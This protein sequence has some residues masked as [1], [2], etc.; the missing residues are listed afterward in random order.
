MSRLQ[1][2]TQVTQ[3]QKQTISGWSV[4]TK[5]MSKALKAQLEK[6][7]KIADKD[8]MA[9]RIKHL[10]QVKK[11]FK[12]LRNGIIQ[13]HRTNGRRVFNS[14]SSMERTMRPGF[15]ANGYQLVEF[16]CANSH[17]LLLCRMFTD[18][19]M[20][21]E[22]EMI[23][24]AE[25]G[26][27]YSI[28]KGDREEVKVSVYSCF[29]NKTGINTRNPV[30]LVLK[31]KY[32]LFAAA[33]ME[34]SK[35]GAHNSLSKQM[36][37]KEADIWIDVVSKALMF[38]GIPHATTHDG[39]VFAKYSDQ[40]VAD[41]YTVIM[42]AYDTI[43]PTLHFETVAKEPVKY[44]PA[45][46]PR[47]QKFIK[48]ARM[49]KGTSEHDDATAAAIAEWTNKWSAYVGFISFTGIKGEIE[50]TIQ[51][52]DIIGFLENRGYR[53]VKTEG[54]LRKYVQ[55]KNNIITKC[56]SDDMKHELTAYIKKE[57]PDRIFGISRK[58]ILNAFHRRPEIKDGVHYSF[59]PPLTE[60]DL[61]RTRPDTA[62]KS[63]IPFKNGV[64]RVTSDGRRVIPYNKYNGF[65][66]SDAIIPL[67]YWQ[68][69][70]SSGDLAKFLYNIAGPTPAK[71]EEAAAKMDI[72]HHKMQLEEKTEAYN[73]LR[74][75]LGYLCHSFKDRTEAKMVILMDVN[76]NQPEIGGAG[77]SL[78]ISLTGLIR[79]Y[80][81]VRGQ[82]EKTEWQFD[83][84][85]H[86]AQVINIDDMKK[87]YPLSTLNTH[88][89]SDF[90][91]NVK[92]G[93]M[94]IIPFSVAGKLA[95]TTNFM[96]DITHPGVKRRVR[97]YE[98]NN[99]YSDEF[100]PKTDF[101][102][103]LIDDWSSDQMM[104]EINFMLEGL[105]MYLADGLSTSRVDDEKAKV[106]K[107]KIGDD[108][109]E[110]IK[111]VVADRRKVLPS[112]HPTM[113]LIKDVYELCEYTVPDLQQKSEVMTF[114]RNLE[115]YL[116]VM[117][118]KFRKGVETNAY[119]QNRQRGYRFI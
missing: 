4:D 50:A 26:D 6:C 12:Q 61:K 35:K 119:T 116:H 91:I 118:I 88:I 67:N 103:T 34:S 11:T 58:T 44:K 5:L 86:S 48:W 19:G 69:D 57:L 68:T 46:S 22:P 30:Y 41:V 21:V 31:T 23:Q 9:K 106:I 96:P 51:N 37:A 71:I 113:E 15:G 1:E 87:Y 36:Q 99:H 63:Y 101:G 38:A 18:N 79:P 112:F 47:M 110:S 81:E 27:F 80:K 45:N 65:V 7:N 98:I 49:E 89:T 53:K 117:K 92:S 59:L 111:E 40:V 95:G 94:Y 97:I 39:V 74:K 114:T 60:N 17:P 75:M 16:D 24:L 13:S 102:H 43:T 42:A 55:I 104:M 25:S 100:D 115:L 76:T 64:L 84:V 93:G 3:Y 70:T 20:D 77:K 107:M 90:E 108:M 83:G 56:D 85:E 14:V 78:T 28:F 2:I 109:Y 29:Y 10:K 73:D 66:W 33:L 72:D 54:S 62:K 82:M 105:Q 52:A 8:K 32:P